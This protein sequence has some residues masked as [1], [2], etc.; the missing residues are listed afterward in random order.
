[1]SILNKLTRSSSI[2]WSIFTVSLRCSFLSMSTTIILASL[3]NKWYW[4]P[5]EGILSEV[6]NPIIRSALATAKLPA[7]VPFKPILP[8]YNGWSSGNK[9]K[10]K[11]V[12]TTGIW[13]FSINSIKASL[14]FDKLIPLP[15]IIIGLSA[16]FK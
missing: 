12:T 10:P 6:P 7:L 4:Y 11:K 16:L 2:I 14:V 3:P 8:I 15:A 13:C 9:F 1:M 5:V